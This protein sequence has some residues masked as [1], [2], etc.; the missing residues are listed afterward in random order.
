MAAGCA[1]FVLSVGNSLKRH[2]LNV[3]CSLE[4][5]GRN[6]L[7]CAS[8]G[9]SLRRKKLNICVL[10]RSEGIIS[11]YLLVQMFSEFYQR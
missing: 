5:G 8:L 9:D 10:W 7:L 11:R 2:K 1:Y 6:A 3:L 4:K